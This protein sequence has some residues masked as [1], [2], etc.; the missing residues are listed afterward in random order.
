MRDQRLWDVPTQGPHSQ[1]PLLRTGVKDHARCQWEEIPPTGFPDGEPS[2]RD[3]RS[4]KYLAWPEWCIAIDGPHTGAI[5]LELLWAERSGKGV[6]TKP[7]PS[8]YHS[9]QLQWMSKARRHRRVT[10]IT[11]SGFPR[12]ENPLVLSHHCRG[13]MYS[14]PKGITLDAADIRPI[15]FLNC[16]T[17]SDRP[18]LILLTDV[19]IDS[20][21]AGDIRACIVVGFHTTP[22]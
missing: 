11:R 15:S 8:L 4:E 12:E 2:V 6:Q 19:S 17:V 14:R 20:I 1:L 18:S 3:I 16:L 22:R 5:S 10:L 9:I 7:R 21:R 13:L